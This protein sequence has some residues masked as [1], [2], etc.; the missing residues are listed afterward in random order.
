MK[1]GILGAGIS[2]LATAHYLKGNDITLFEA[3]SRVGGVI[4]STDRFECGPRTFATTRTPNLLALINEMGLADDLQYSPMLARNVYRDGALQKMGWTPS[5]LAGM[6]KDL[7]HPK[8]MRP[9]EPI[10]SFARRHFGENVYRNVIEPLVVGIY[11]GDAEELSLASCFP[12]WKALETKGGSLTLGLLRLSRSK[13]PLYCLKSGMHTLPQK[14]AEGMP[15]R[16]NSLVT[17]LEETPH[18][19][20][21][22]GE[23]FDHVVACLP[24]EILKS[25]ALPQHRAFFK[26]IPTKSISAVTME[27]A[28]QEFP[29]KSFGYLVPPREQRHALGVIF[30]SNIF[31]KPDDTARLT[32]MLSGT[33]D[34]EERALS[35]LRE[36][37]GLVAT[38][39]S[40]C[41]YRYPNY[42]PQFQVGHQERLAQISHP[43]I[44]Y[45]GNYHYGASVESCLTTAKQA[46]QKVQQPV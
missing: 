3:S 6:L 33:D 21:V 18:G 32:V 26:T 8:G 24:A 5:A 12:K 46:S 38:P 11:A 20:S 40:I 16:F 45:V 42:L 31:P 39:K 25:L 19:I 2:G 7:V 37:L 36:Q 44:S 14:L 13:K 1:I 15:I 41:A 9:D 17:S 10:A 43:N 35:D 27:F 22:N 23:I 34:P 28:N 4:Q 29:Q 30:D